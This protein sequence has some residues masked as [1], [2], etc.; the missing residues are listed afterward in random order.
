MPLDVL[1]NP[2]NLILH[3]SYEGSQLILVLHTFLCIHT[4]VQFMGSIIEGYKRPCVMTLLLIMFAPS[5]SVVEV[6]HW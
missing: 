3:I 5:Q 2:I 6:T 1:L 4:T